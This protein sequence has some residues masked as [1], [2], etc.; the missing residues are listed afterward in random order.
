MAGKRQLLAKLVVDAAV[1]KE[2]EQPVS[3]AENCLSVSEQIVG[4]AKTWTK[5]MIV[6]I[7]D[8]A[9][10]AVLPG[11]HHRSGCHVERGLLVVRFIGTCQQVP[12][13]AQVEGQTAAQ[14]PVVLRKYSV[15]LPDIGIVA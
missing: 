9:R 14:A 7:D 13:D 11:K 2:V 12:S 10:N 1:V 3:A 6:C 15:F 8:A 4:K 5:S